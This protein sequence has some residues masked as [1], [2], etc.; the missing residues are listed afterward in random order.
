[1]AINKEMDAIVGDRLLEALWREALWL[2]HDDIGDVETL[3]DVIRY[4]FGLR[5]AQME[6]FQ[7]YR[8]AG[9]QA[10]MRRFLS[11]FVR[12]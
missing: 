7:T 5:W 11:Q 10:G 9:G 12:R 2:I 4:W 8:I 1:M 6:L 3:D